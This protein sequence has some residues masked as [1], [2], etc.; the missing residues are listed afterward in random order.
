MTR[1]LLLSAG[2]SLEDFR[3]RVSEWDIVIGVNRAAAMFPLD[4]WVFAD[5]ACFKRFLPDLASQP[6]R[7]FVKHDWP[8]RELDRVA[9]DRAWLHARERTVWKEAMDLTGIRFSAS[10]PAALSLAA[11]LGATYVE[12]W[13]AD[14]SGP[15]HGAAHP[16]QAERQTWNDVVGF[17]RGYGGDVVHGKGVV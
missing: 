4:W 1:A 17:I 6:K 13:G 2:P 11:L 7:L 16:W 14:M 8:T 15:G 5:L 10:G 12:A 9:A 3:G